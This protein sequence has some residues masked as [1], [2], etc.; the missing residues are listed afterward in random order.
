M[1][2][3]SPSGLL[4][5]SSKLGYV[6]TGKYPDPSEEGS[7]GNDVTSCLVMA[8][9]ETLCLNRFWD[10]DTIGIRDPVYVGEDDKALENFNSTVS[11]SNGRYF[12]TWPWKHSEVDLPENLIWH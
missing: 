1:K 11:H 10:L 5:I 6:L 12:V 9:D 3:V 2:I 8:K 4:L 7:K